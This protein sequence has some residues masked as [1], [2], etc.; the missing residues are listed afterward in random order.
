LISVAPASQVV[1]CGRAVPRWST[2]STEQAAVGSA[3]WAGLL[4]RGAGSVARH[5]KA[6]PAC[7][8]STRL[9][10]DASAEITLTAGW[11][12]PGCTGRTRVP[13]AGSLTRCP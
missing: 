7:L 12:R 9:P 1:P 13:G 2:V 5:P 4:F 10:R 3:L 6:G 8:V 11:F